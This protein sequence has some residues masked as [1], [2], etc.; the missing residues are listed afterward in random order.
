MPDKMKQLTIRLPEKLH[1]AFKIKTA[2]KS[3]SMGQVLE[4]FIVSYV[5]DKKEPVPVSENPESKKKTESTVGAIILD[6]INQSNGIDSAG[7]RDKT[8]FTAAKVGDYVYRLKKQGKIK[9][10]S[11]GVFVAV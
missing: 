3:E 4:A 1:Q 11:D 5:E 7:I 8:G 6:I 10:T 2:Q 9:K